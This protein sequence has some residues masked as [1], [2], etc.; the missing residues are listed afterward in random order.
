MEFGTEGRV[1][2]VRVGTTVPKRHWSFPEPNHMAFV[3]KLNPV[4]AGQDVQ[5]EGLLPGDA[6]EK[7]KHML[8]HV[9]IK[10]EG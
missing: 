2:R 6:K 7:V 9:F 10:H 5:S 1:A 3:P 8:M 4:N